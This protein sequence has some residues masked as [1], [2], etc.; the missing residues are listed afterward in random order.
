MSE[1]FLATPVTEHMNFLPYGSAAIDTMVH[2]TD[3]A[4]TL[5]AEQHQQYR[6]STPPLDAAAALAA[7]FGLG[8]DFGV[9]SIEKVDA[10]AK[11]HESGR[12]WENVGIDVLREHFSE[13]PSQSRSPEEVV[14]VSQHLAASDQPP[15]D[16][17]A[18]LAAS[19]GFGIAVAHELSK[20]AKTSRLDGS[21]RITEI[22]EDEPKPSKEP[23][24]TEAEK[25]KKKFKK[26]TGTTRERTGCLTCRQRYVESN[27]ELHSHKIPLFVRL[28]DQL[29]LSCRVP[30]A[31][32]RG[33]Q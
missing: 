13:S 25:P 4:A 21:S 19:F 5:R 12:R 11:V 20:E 31:S 26:R 2:I 30:S 29:C 15:V 3:D 14:E 22:V 33:S 9:P 16:A 18:A 8:Y 27:P 7:S 24:K 28:Y 17:A 23:A 10:D 6:S 1:T 32:P